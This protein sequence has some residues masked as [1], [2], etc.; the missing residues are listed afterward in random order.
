MTNMTSATRA[1]VQYWRN[2]EYFMLKH[3]LRNIG[4]GLLHARISS[5]EEII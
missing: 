3:C 1:C 5:K 4:E 2:N